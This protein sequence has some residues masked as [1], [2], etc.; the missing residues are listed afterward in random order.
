MHGRTCSVGYI[1]RDHLTVHME[2]LRLKKYNKHEENGR[3]SGASF[4]V[5]LRARSINLPDRAGRENEIDAPEST[6]P[7]FFC[8]TFCI[9][10]LTEAR[11]SYL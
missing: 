8:Y 4:S 2:G 1:T 3:H 7:P 9:T 6:I 11:H 5:P 10:Q